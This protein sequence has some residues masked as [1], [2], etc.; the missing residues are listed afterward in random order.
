M[1]LARNPVLPGCHPDP[2]VCRVGEEFFVVTS[3]FE[4]FPGLP[5]HRSR[6]LVHWELVGHAIHR[7]TQ[8]DLS[9]V[10]SSGGLFAPTIRHHDGR[11]LVACTLVG[12]T[13]RSGSFVVTATDAA[14]PWSDPVWVEEAEGIDPSILVDRAGRAWWSGT[15]LA[16]PPA[17]PEQT[18]VWV[19]ELDLETLQLVGEERVVWNGALTGAVWAEGPH[20]YDLGDRDGDTSADIASGGGILLLASEGGTERHHAVSVAMADSPLGEYRGNPG[21]PVLTHRHL[22]ASAP[23]ANVGHA[24]LFDDGRGGW[25]ITALATRRV[26]GRDALQARETWL[27]PVAWEHGWPVLAPGLGRL[28]DTVDVP[29]ADAAGE[30]SVAGERAERSLS[31]LLDEAVHPELALVR[32]APDRPRVTV[33]R[34]ADA[35]RLHPSSRS[36]SETAPHAVLAWRLEEMRATLSASV[37]VSS[38]PASGADT[39]S[40]DT[41]S[42]D[43]ASGDASSGDSSSGDTSTGAASGG[44]VLRLSD[45]RFVTLALRRAIGGEAAA[46]DVRI[47]LARHVDGVD[48][49]IAVAVPPAGTGDGEVALVLEVDGFTCRA[50]VDGVGLGDAD[51]AALSPSEGG[52][53]FGV[54]AGAFAV[55]A[56]TTIATFSDLRL[57]HHA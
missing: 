38:H 36:L 46:S 12:G 3:S 30:S 15:R 40:A 13:G 28:T 17:W 43:T 41:A 48:E 51:L 21:N 2:S 26:D 50:S 53:F 19:R 45:A 39:A 24:D 23:V 35:V 55:G 11:F 49:V 54:L 52:G 20:L 47:E 18:E 25:W 16:D 22:G 42:A 56:P 33:D 29:W 27:A 10:R 7:E 57:A 1:A 14:G 4:L 37:A 44:L 6:D 31:G 34:A 32:T 5:V 8:V 9:G